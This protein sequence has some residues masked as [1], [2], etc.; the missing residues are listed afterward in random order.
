MSGGDLFFLIFTGI[1]SVV[2]V[3]FASIGAGVLHTWRAR[4]ARCDIRTTGMV[5]ELAPAG[6][7]LVPVVEYTVYGKTYTLRGQRG[8]TDPPFLLGDSVD[9][10]YNGDNPAEGYF[11][12]FVPLRV[13]GIVFV[14]VGCG[15]LVIG[16]TVGLLVRSF[17]F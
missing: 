17:A 6:L 11:E 10:Y 16:W 4:R 9:V 12:A 3:I 8:Y 2:G 13:L 7:Q 5:R 14:C 15:A 1:W